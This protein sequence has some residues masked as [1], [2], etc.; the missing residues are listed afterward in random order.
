MS[1]QVLVLKLSPF[2]LEKTSSWFEKNF[3]SI[4]K[5]YLLIRKSQLTPLSDLIRKF[6]DLG[7]EKVREVSIPGEFS[8]RDCFVDIFP[9]NFV[10]SRL[11]FRIEFFGRPLLKDKVNEAM[12]TRIFEFSLLRKKC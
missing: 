1:R 9:V 7:Y 4:C 12:K 11:A 10:N 5:Q 3:N 2:F 8:Q 6:L